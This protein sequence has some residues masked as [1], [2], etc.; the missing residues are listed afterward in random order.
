LLLRGWPPLPPPLPPSR[1]STLGARWRESSAWRRQERCGGGG[2]RT[3]LA[4]ESDGMHAGGRARGRGAMRAQCGAPG[5]LGG[6]SD[7]FGDFRVR[8]TFCFFV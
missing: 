4:E 7:G 2:A 5:E 1:E 8:E 6:E 3:D